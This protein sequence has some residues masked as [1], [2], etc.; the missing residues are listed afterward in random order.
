MAA[1]EDEADAEEAADT[2]CGVLEEGQ[3]DEHFG[4]S[5]GE[6][7]SESKDSSIDL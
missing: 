7:G 3:A 2:S 4:D 1:D 6:K 5:S